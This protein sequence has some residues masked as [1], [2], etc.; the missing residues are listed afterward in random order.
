MEFLA[1]RPM[2]SEN[3]VIRDHVMQ[4]GASDPSLMRRSFDTSVAIKNTDNESDTRLLRSY[5]ESVFDTESLL[6]SSPS[7]GNDVTQILVGEFLDLLS[8]D[9]SVD[10]MFSKAI[11]ES[12]IGPERFKKNF[13]RILRSYSRQLSFSLT[14]EVT[15]HSPKY[16]DVVDF[17]RRT[18]TQA[19]SFLVERYKEQDAGTQEIN[20]SQALQY[21]E[22]PPESEAESSSSNEEQESGR[23]EFTGACSI[24]DL[25]SFF[26]SSEPFRALKWRLRA[27]VIPTRELEKV[28]SSTEHLLASVWSSPPLFF[29]LS[30]ARAAAQERGLSFQTHITYLISKLA[31]ELGF[32]NPSLEVASGFLQAYSDYIAARCSEKIISTSEGEAE[33]C[34]TELGMNSPATSQ[35]D[36]QLGGG[37]LMPSVS[38]EKADDSSPYNQHLRAD[39]KVAGG[40]GDPS[41]RFNHSDAVLEDI[42]ADTLPEI[43]DGGFS[44]YWTTMV[45]SKAVRNFARGLYNFI[46]PTFFSEARSFILKTVEEARIELVESEQTRTEGLRLLPIFKEIEHCSVRKG[47][48]HN[49]TIRLDTDRCLTDL[50][51][52]DR[53]K[54]TIEASTGS[55]WDWW[56]LAPPRDH[57][58]T[59]F[60]AHSSLSIWKL[61]EKYAREL[62]GAFDF[63][64]FLL[65]PLFSFFLL[66]KPWASV[67]PLRVSSSWS[68]VLLS[69]IEQYSLILGGVGALLSM[70]WCFVA[71]NE[72]WSFLHWVF[73][74][75][76]YP[77]GV[78]TTEP[79]L[80]LYRRPSRP[81][82]QQ[83]DVLFKCEQCS[84]VFGREH[85][86]KRHKRTH[87]AAKLLKCEQVETPLTRE[88]AVCP[89]RL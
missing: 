71:C 42:M 58:K 15:D 52:V 49:F 67:L 11:S 68:Y 16:R 19:S 43:F 34:V 85:A 57:Y 41:S 89:T 20:R 64:L 2:R 82:S 18:A 40:F 51:P 36:S 65:A 61:W 53:L 59:E 3:L 54:L 81:Q 56:P 37:V 38:F 47:V 73:R 33:A 14:K 17:I 80:R 50:S 13:K 62:S 88:D 76:L 83:E 75:S 66:H 46:N 22:S 35:P 29:S 79:L 7:L 4:K 86:F 30:K 6:S 69:Y 24:E 45:S 8:E 87:Q 78:L 74:P 27:L 1:T 32:E 31:V 10:S 23:R 60:P 48:D 72:C 70:R 21:H 28:K 26:I 9:P 12:G 55:K 5:A 39:D 77:G 63:M 25:K 44:V 84:A